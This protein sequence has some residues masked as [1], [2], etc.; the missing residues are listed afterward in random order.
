[1]VSVGLLKSE[2][3]GLGPWGWVGGIGDGRCVRLGRDV[4]LDSYRVVVQVVYLH[5]PRAFLAV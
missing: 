5:I 3:R 2:A 1:M 4:V